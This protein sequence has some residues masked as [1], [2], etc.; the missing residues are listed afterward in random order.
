MKLKKL[1]L[2]MNI[3]EQNLTLSVLK[4]QKKFQV[5]WTCK[6]IYLLKEKTKRKI[7]YW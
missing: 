1:P 5:D 2:K 3:S 7:R 4:Y 6:E